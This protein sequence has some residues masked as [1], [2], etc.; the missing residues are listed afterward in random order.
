MELIRYLLI[1]IVKRPMRAAFIV[2]AGALSSL[3][4]VFAFSLG[5]RVTEHIHADTIAK[6]TGHLW[7]S[8]ADDFAFKEEKE[9][10]Y[11]REAAALR[12]YL[13]SSRDAAIAVPWMLKYCDMQ[14][15][16]AREYVG[17]Q[18]MDF[19]ADLPFKAATELVSGT[20]PGPKDEYGMLITTAMADKYRL[21]LGDS[22]TI[23]MPTAFGARNA[24]DFVVTGICR[25]S[26][27]WYDRTACVRAA[28][29]LAMTELEGMSP[30]YKVYVK[31]EASIPRMVKDMAALAPDFIVKGYKD[32]KFVQFLFSLGTS[33]TAIFGAM[34]MIIFLA[35]LIGINS[36][37]LTNVFDRRDEIGTLRAIGFSRGTVCNL[38]FGES[39]LSLLAGYLVG[40]A[41]VSA[42]GAYFEAHLVAP[43]LLML[44]YMFGMTRMGISLTPLTVFAPL[45]LLLALLFLASYRRVGLETEKQ[46][47]AQMANR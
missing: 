7:V 40:V 20:F 31:D 13:A 16:T 41:L 34:A 38:F 36:I 1:N 9:A 3:V 27:P 33:N 42:I 4:L 46:A 35:L 43:P 14:A 17:V 22:V 44:Q 2:A 23:F 39:L 26:A 6:W 45:A 12:S 25:S 11:R 37:I 47:A 28:D 5:V 32:D 24:M 30:F 18:G 19:E 10:D 8:A 29:Y 15:G 21:K